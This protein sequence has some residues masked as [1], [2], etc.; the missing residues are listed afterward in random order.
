M[1]AEERSRTVG[2]FGRLAA[3]V[4]AGVAKRGTRGHSRMSEESFA[5]W[6]S[7]EHNDCIVSDNLFPCGRSRDG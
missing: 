6:F 2:Q 4:D 3:D 7:K 1:K 5:I